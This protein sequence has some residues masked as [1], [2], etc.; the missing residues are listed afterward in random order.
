MRNGWSHIHMWWVKI[1]RNTSRVKDPSHI[2][3]HPAQGSSAKK[4]SPHNLCC[5]NQWGCRQWKKL[6]DSQEPPL[7]GPTMNLGLMQTHPAH[8]LCCTHAATVGRAPVA[9]WEKLKCLASG[10]VPGD[11]FLQDKTPEDRQQH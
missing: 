1:G 10:Q 4:I 5:K 3:D 11:S 6:Q 9:Y 8:P 7:K 2:P